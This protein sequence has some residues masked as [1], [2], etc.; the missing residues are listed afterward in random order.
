L[1]KCGWF[2]LSDDS[3]IICC[4]RRR[5]QLSNSGRPSAAQRRIISLARPSHVTSPLRRCSR[6]AR[7]LIIV[8][9][10]VRVL[11]GPPRSPG[12]TE[13]SRFFMKSPELAG[14]RARILSLQGVDWIS[15]VVWGLCPCPAKS[16]FPTAEA[17]VVYAAAATAVPL[18]TRPS[19]PVVIFTFSPSLMR[20]DSRSSASG[21]CT[22]RWIT[23]FNGRAP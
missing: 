13:I 23:R 22:E 16:R 3:A 20:P 1:G 6:T 11:P 19:R 10:A 5:S 9:L 4:R 21:S 18:K 7:Y 8:W 15:G 12:Q 2:A 17:G 14:I